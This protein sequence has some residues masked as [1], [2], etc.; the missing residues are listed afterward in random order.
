MTAVN[1]TD[2][3]SYA[4]SARQIANAP[5]IVRVSP[6]GFARALALS[7]RPD[8]MVSKAEFDDLTSRILADMQAKTDALRLFRKALEGLRDTFRD[9]DMS[10]TPQPA[11]REIHPTPRSVHE[12]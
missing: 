3:R 5:G 12:P 9:A 6:S 4:E 7:N 1:T 10:G 2:C 11:Y 8:R